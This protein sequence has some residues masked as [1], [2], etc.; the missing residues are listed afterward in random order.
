MKI[1]AGLDL[2]VAV[3]AESEEMTRTLTAEKLLADKTTIADY[4]VTRPVEA[5]LAAIREAIDLAQETGCKLHIVHVSCGRGVKLVAAAR[6][7]GVDV[8]CETCP[9]YLLL[10]A[11]SMRRGG[12]AWKCAPPLREHR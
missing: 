2:L 8:S 11:E 3:H 9:H 6:S 7:A 1:A 12:A 5:E 10:N 4:L